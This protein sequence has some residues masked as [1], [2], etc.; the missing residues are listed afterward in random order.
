MKTNLL[1]ALAVAVLATGTV[2]PIAQAEAKT[3]KTKQVTGVGESAGAVA[4]FRE[5]RAL[6]RAKITYGI[7]VSK[8][9]GTDFRK[10][11]KG[12]NQKERCE[13]SEGGNT[14]CIVSAI[15]CD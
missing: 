15:P 5:R 7:K 13:L 1:I 9:F 6:R 8:D 4:K 11:S 3:C 10:F 14:R 2:F 12:K